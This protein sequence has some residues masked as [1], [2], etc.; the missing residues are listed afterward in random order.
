MKPER[1][2]FV[3][4]F[5]PRQWVKTNRFADK[6]VNIPDNMAMA[7]YFLIVENK[8]GNVLKYINNK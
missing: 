6:L 4:Y 5:S 7:A 8:N 2:H 1:M 3:E